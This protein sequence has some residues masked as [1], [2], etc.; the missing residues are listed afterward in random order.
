MSLGHSLM[1]ALRI[2]MVM[3]R[4][5]KR[6]KAVSEGHSQWLLSSLVALLSRPGRLTT[7]PFH[8]QHLLPLHP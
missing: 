4:P 8:S 2:A 5:L 7:W 3:S 1:S 6:E